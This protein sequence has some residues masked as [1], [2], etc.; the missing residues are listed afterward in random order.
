M[1]VSQAEQK[2]TFRAG[3][4][5]RLGN[6][7]RIADPCCQGS[8]FAGQ[9]ID[10]EPDVIRRL[11]PFDSFDVMA[12]VKTAQ[13]GLPSMTRYVLKRE[14]GEVHCEL[15]CFPC[16]SMIPG[17][18]ACF[19]LD[20]TAEAAAA[21]RLEHKVSTL[22]II[23]QVIKAFAE[24]HNLSDVLRII[25]LGV[26]AG[27]GLGFNRGFILLSNEQRTQ[28]WG[29]LATGP[30][31]PE[32]AGKIWQDLARRKLTLE[33]TLRLYRS[34]SAEVDDIHVN[35]LVASLKISLADDTNFIVRA[36]RE[37]RSLIT[38]PENIY[39]PS[40]RQLAEKIGTDI[41]AVVPLF[42]HEYL[43]GVLVAD[44]LI[45]AKPISQSDLSVLEIFARYAA[46]AIENSRL[47]GKLE[48]QI[49]RLRE[50][51]EKIVQSREHLIKA[52]KLSSVAKMALEVAHEI[53]NP[54]TVLLN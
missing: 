1:P 4:F 43:Q 53:R 22:D 48:Q 24:T 50:A 25:L 34:A 20:R 23:N 44:N 47:Y 42:S 19:L 11:I 49:Y 30:S 46:D 14:S 37:G 41:M 54:L 16:P 52:E 35:R 17:E 36:V 9:R 15:H 39:C 2:Q 10:S 28:L 21:T 7:E 38:S 26:T 5:F 18:V 31:T 3:I 40:S 8:H 12:S 33:D 32:E 45:T 27:S 51:N 6:N 29:C 13:D